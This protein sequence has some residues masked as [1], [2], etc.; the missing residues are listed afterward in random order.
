MQSMLLISFFITVAYLKGTAIVIQ[1]HIKKATVYQDFQLKI[2]LTA[3]EQRN[4]IVSESL[5][6]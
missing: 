6:D 2:R 1:L 4:A 5:E 3:Q